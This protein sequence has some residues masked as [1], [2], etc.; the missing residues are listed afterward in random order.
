MVLVGESVESGRKL[1]RD[2]NTG[3]KMIQVNSNGDS[4]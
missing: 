3:S 2:E 4:P 1:D